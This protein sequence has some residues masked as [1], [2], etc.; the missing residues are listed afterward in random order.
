LKSLRVKNFESHRDTTV[1]FSPGV[2]IITGATDV[3]KSSL[4]RACEW[5]I[6]NRPLGTEFINWDS[7]AATVILDGVEK[8]RSRNGKHFYK[9]HGKVYKAFGH[10]VPGAI[11]RELRLT[12]ENIQEQHDP[13]FLINDSPGRVAQVLNS[14][15]DLSLIDR[16]LK[17]GKKRIRKIITRL[18]VIG[19][20]F[21]ER[22]AKRE[23]LL[24][25][26]E[27]I[28]KVKQYEQ[29]ERARSALSNQ[30]GVLEDLV[31]RAQDPEL[32]ILNLV[33]R[34]I[35]QVKTWGLKIDDQETRIKVLQSLISQAKSPVQPPVTK[36]LEQVQR[37]KEGLEETRTQV[38]E[39]LL[40]KASP[41]TVPPVTK[42]TQVLQGLRDKAKSMKTRIEDL[43]TGIKACETSAKKLRHLSAN[44]EQQEEDFEAE[45]K[46]LGVCP[47]C[48][49]SL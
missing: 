8:H 43:E 13:Y 40:Q 14:V 25:T 9:C 12:K 15:T 45:L 44:Y 39:S 10:G 41:V 33:A 2:N 26:E 31:T 29:F 42:D 27:A 19:E 49:G 1:D 3:G 30:I 38:L 20:Q 46:S 22:E 47:L 35:E 18:E 24:W 28:K 23:A 34:D 11:T 7:K 16:C 48:G 37:I 32:R 4:R 6:C 5:V 36:D 21:D 17:E